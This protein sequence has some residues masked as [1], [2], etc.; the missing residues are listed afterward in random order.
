VLIMAIG[1]FLLWRS[2]KNDH[3]KDGR[4]GRT[5]AFVTGFIPC[6][7][8]TFIVSYAL[9][10]GM[11]VAGLTVTAAMTAGMIVTIGGVAL[12]AA[13]ARDRFVQL[14]A[15]TEAWRHRAGLSSWAARWRCSVSA[16]GR[17]CAAY[18][19][20]HWRRARHNLLPQRAS[21]ALTGRRGLDYGPH[22]LGQGFASG[23]QSPFTVALGASHE[24]Q[25][26]A[27]GLAQAPS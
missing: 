7:L 11:L 4:D 1:G 21:G 27:Q 23:G 22:R 9:A 24:D 20:D 25:E 15:R 12:A 5:L 26:F 17:R 14:L 19:W 16:L 13:F 8:T 18:R 10:R 2:L 3:H 6:P